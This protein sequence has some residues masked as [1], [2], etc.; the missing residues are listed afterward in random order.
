MD[1]YDKLLSYGK[2]CNKLETISLLALVLTLT[3]SSINWFLDVV[4]RLSATKSP[5]T[6]IL[7]LLFKAN[8][9]FSAWGI[10]IDLQLMHPLT[11]LNLIHHLT[12]M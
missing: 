1:P 8:S 3:L 7:P 10:L 9:L 4:I 6:V 12:Q 11:W 2:L 5:S